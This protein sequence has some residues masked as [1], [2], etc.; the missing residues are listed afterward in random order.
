MA[1]CMI[2][3]FSALSEFVV[4]KVFCEKYKE[5]KKAEQSANSETAI[6][7]WRGNI[8]L[9][10]KRHRKSVQTLFK[11]YWI[12]KY[13]HEKILWCEV[14]RL[15]AIIFPVLFLIFMIIYWPLLVIGKSYA[16]I[17]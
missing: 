10:L 3:V 12:N 5:K 16:L 4:V 15:S 6:A 1:A 17:A 2:F 8:K 13:G 14:D 11:Y 7:A 9:E